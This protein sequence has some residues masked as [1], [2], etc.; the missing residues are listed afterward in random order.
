MQNY[1]TVLD[2]TTWGIYLNFEE[3]FASRRVEKPHL[4]GFVVKLG[5]DLFVRTCKTVGNEV[6]PQW[7]SAKSLAVYI[8]NITYKREY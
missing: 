2:Q 8:R 1:S 3:Y 4:N 5:F 7:L 6:N